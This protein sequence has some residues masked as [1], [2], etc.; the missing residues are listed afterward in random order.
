MC[1]YDVLY[2]FML[3]LAFL[4]ECQKKSPLIRGSFYS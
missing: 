4:N 2:M 3:I 1:V